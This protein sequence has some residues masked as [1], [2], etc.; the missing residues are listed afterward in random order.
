MKSIKLLHLFAAVLLAASC[1]AGMSP[2]GGLA[3]APAAPAAVE[4]FLQLAAVNDYSGM[5]WIFGTVEGPIL[6]R[7]P[8]SEVEQRM[9]ALA[10]LLEHDGFVVGTG[11]PVPGR[12]AEALRFNVI[13]SRGGQALTVP[14]TAVRGPGDRWFVEELEVEAITG[15]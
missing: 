6:E 5:G 7:D 8:R 10:G 14:F 1:S 4:R 11:S 9:Y 3:G 2:P 15:R 13:L 12:T